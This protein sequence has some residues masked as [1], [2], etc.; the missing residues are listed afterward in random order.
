MSGPRFQKTLGLVLSDTISPGLAI[1][2]KRLTC[3]I[4]SPPASVP[5]VQQPLVDYTGT[6]VSDNKGNTYLIGRLLGEGASGKVHQVDDF[7]RSDPSTEHARLALKILTPGVHHTL[8]ERSIREAR[9]LASFNHPAILRCHDFFEHDGITFLV[10]D[11]L[12]GYPLSS[13]L[14]STVPL[15]TKLELMDKIVIA[16]VVAEALVEVHKKAVHRDIKPENIFLCSEDHT[17][18]RILD[19]VKLIDFGIAKRIHSHEIDIVL[20]AMGETFGT[21]AYMSPEQLSAP[22]AVDHR[23]DLY[24]FGVILY[25]MLTNRLPFIGGQADI[26]RGHLTQKP[27]P[28]KRVNPEVSDKLQNLVLK[29]LSKSKT[30]RYPDAQTVADELRSLFIS[31][32]LSTASDQ[33]TNLSSLFMRWIGG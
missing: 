33:H 2:A 21:P 17:K 29:L 18:P 4:G 7:R 13:I 20:T 24:S 14:D 3:A 12:L 25:E 9:I 28:I 15:S 19:A 5:L 22:V 8:K 16:I 32:E 31:G 6:L 30:E 1:H 23:S 10:L 26:I 27:E 11:H